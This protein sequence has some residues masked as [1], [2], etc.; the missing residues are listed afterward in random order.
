[1]IES[2]W[3]KSKDEKL[4]NRGKLELMT[5]NVVATV[6]RAGISVLRFEK[7]FKALPV[8]QIGSIFDLKDYF[9][10]RKYKIHGQQRF[11]KRNRPFFWFIPFLN[12][13]RGLLKYE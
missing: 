1:M 4:E 12:L 10:F 7:L 13:C 8:G 9:F 11:Q 2:L 5:M 6:S 3:P